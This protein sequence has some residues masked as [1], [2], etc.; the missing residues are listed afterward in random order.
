MLPPE[1][2]LASVSARRRQGIV[3][4]RVG[5]GKSGSSAG[6]KQQRY[7]QTNH[8]QEF[9]F[10]AHELDLSSFENASAWMQRSRMKFNLSCRCGSGVRGRGSGAWGQRHENH[11]LAIGQ[12]DVPGGIGSRNPKKSSQPSPNSGMELPG[13]QIPR[14]K[15]WDGRLP[16]ASASHGRDVG[17]L[18]SGRAP[19]PC[20]I[21]SCSLA[22]RQNLTRPLRLP[23]ATVF[24]SGE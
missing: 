15:R 5:D 21:T 10:S 11:R 7:G 14:G 20:S 1:I 3:E 23:L 4:R 18:E 2:P 13:D 16:L 12:C 24:P 8:Q 9:K 17:V 22:V 19:A 6:H